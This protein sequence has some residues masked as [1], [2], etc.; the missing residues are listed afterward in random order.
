MNTAVGGTSGEKHVVCEEGLLTV[1]EDCESAS[2]QLDFLKTV[3]QP[4]MMA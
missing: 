2:K 1:D 4:G 3:Y